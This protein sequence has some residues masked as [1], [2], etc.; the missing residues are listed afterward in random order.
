MNLFLILLAS[1]I[2]SACATKYSCDAYSAKPVKNTI[3]S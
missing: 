3:T 1:L 2:L